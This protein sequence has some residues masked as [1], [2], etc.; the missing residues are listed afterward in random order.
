MLSEQNMQA[1][2]QFNLPMLN[3]MTALSHEDTMPQCGWRP[4]L[5]CP[6]VMLPI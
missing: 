6:T 3:K 1:T 5:K 2:R 4:L